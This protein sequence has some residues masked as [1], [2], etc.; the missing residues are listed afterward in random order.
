MEGKKIGTRYGRVSLQSLDGVG[1]SAQEYQSQL[2]R[3]LA[4]LMQADERLLGS[5]A[6]HRIQVVDCRIGVAGKVGMD[7]VERC[8]LR[9]A[10]CIF[11]AD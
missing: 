2:D 3:F 5:S 7:K 6:G 1:S 4:K 8:H 9:E 10:Y 11:D